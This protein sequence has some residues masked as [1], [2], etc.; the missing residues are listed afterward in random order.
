[1]A[2]LGKDNI[3]EHVRSIGFV[4]WKVYQDA[5]KKTAGN[6]VGTADFANENLGLEASLVAL[7]QLLDR[8]TPGQYI[9]TAY[10]KPKD[11][12][13]GIDTTIEISGS[14]SSSAISGVAAPAAFA[15]A[16]FGEVTAD[17]FEQ[18]MEY[19]M[20]KLHEQQ[21][22][23]KEFERIKKENADLKKQLKE[24]E[25]GFQRGIISI[26]SVLYGT[27]SKTDAGKDLIGMVKDVM[28]ANRSSAA[29]A[30]T[31]EITDTNMIGSTGEEHQPTNDEERLINAVG[32]L[33]KDN[34]DF[35]E[36]IELMAK[37]KEEDPATFQ[38]GV[39]ALR[40]IA[41]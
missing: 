2:L 12:R 36:Q 26:G 27:I 5:T 1:M 23:E 35:L 19:K 39:D 15:I 7:R 10:P 21:E 8:M 40:T 13:S 22:K 38:E 33:S 9:L 20:K 6:F 31:T 17:N 4:Y 14:S 18:A 32:R 28:K 30:G 37:V 29:A 24:S 34:P 16:G 41:G 3:I 11:T 25:S